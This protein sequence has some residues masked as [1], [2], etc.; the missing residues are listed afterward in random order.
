MRTARTLP[1]GGS[2]CPLDR[3][4]PPLTETPPLD[5]DPLDKDPP[6]QRP[7][8]RD[9]LD[10]DPPG[11]RPP[12]TEIPLDRD[13]PEQRPPGTET[14][15]PWTD[16]HLWKHKNVKWFH[17]RAVP[18]YYSARISQKTAQNRI[19]WGRGGAGRGWRL[20]FVCV[21]PSLDVSVLITF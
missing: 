17:Q 15:L 6:E 1:Y 16:R 19:K 21:N 13:T 9:P 12:W 3:D 5:K 7:P 4:P 2:L 14:P 10:R 20:R 18:T 8:D 11:Q